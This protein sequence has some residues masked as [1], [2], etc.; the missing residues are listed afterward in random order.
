MLAGAAVFKDGT[1]TTA[2]FVGLD[3]SLLLRAQRPAPT[4]ATRTTEPTVASRGSCAR[5]LFNVRPP[6]LKRA[7]SHPAPSPVF[8]ALHQFS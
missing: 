3:S 4:I 2:S 6:G 5:R 7:L 8:P 1:L